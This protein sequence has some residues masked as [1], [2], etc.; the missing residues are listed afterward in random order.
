MGSDT[1]RESYLTEGL[2]VFLRSNELLFGL[3]KRELK[4]RDEKLFILLAS[5][6]NTGYG[7]YK[8]LNGDVHTENE[9]YALMRALLEKLTNFNYLRVSND[10]ELEKYFMH[11]Y[12]RMYHSAKRDM[13]GPSTYIK[14]GMQESDVLKLSKDPVIKRALELFSEDK[15]YLN[16]TPLS[17]EKRLRIVCQKT[18]INESI[19]MLSSLLTYKDAS[20][21]LHGSHYGTIFLTGIFTPGSFVN[22]ANPQKSEVSRNISKKLILPLMLLSSF[23]IATSWLVADD[24]GYIDIKTEMKNI[25]TKI[26]EILKSI[27]N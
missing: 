14:L 2:S 1:L 24:Y 10:V 26:T 17:F 13:H 5:C 6:S 8:L 4:G 18:S 3:T 22:P 12:Y 11:A 16:W 20:E 25:E 15:S 21:A 19:L 7:V 23:V 9:A 27:Q